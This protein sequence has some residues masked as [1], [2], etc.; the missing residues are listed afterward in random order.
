M[1]YDKEKNMY[2]VDEKTKIVLDVLRKHKVMPEP[3][4]Y[5]EEDRFL[6]GCLCEVSEE[7]VVAL[8]GGQ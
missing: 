5:Y 7:I 2:W 3:C 1:E 8:R 4:T 6:M